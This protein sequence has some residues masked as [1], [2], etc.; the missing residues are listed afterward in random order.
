[1]FNYI[2]T[3]FSAAAANGVSPADDV[4]NYRHLVVAM[5]TAGSAALRIQI[6]G[7]ISD[8][9]PDFSAAQAADNQYEALQLKDLQ[10]G[11]SLNGDDGLLLSGTDDH[12]LFEVNTNGIK[13][14]A[15]K[16]SSRTA[17]NATVAIRPF[18]DC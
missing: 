1:M 4:S 17:G 5:D 10:S 9:C 16:I 13:W 3:L 18:S 12:R 7:S 2:K 6:L 15:A 14:V 11:A 8:E